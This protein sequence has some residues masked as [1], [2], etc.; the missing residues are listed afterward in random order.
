[1]LSGP[2]M[3]VSPRPLLVDKQQPRLHSRSSA[4]L[5]FLSP[6]GRRSCTFS[7]LL[8]QDAAGAI[9]RREW[10]S[11][12]DQTLRGALAA[13]RLAVPCCQTDLCSPPPATSPLTLTT[14][15]TLPFRLHDC[16]S[17]LFPSFFNPST[18]LPRP[19]EALRHSCWIRT[20]RASTTFSS[21]TG[22]CV[23]AGPPA[24]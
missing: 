17:V 13:A 18:W 14:L 9:G 16:C 7:R 6:L 8:S 3:P 24:A 15:P 2:G 20:R 10:H 21:A 5:P 12:T 22:S 4:S 11:R 23:R 1:M 19:W